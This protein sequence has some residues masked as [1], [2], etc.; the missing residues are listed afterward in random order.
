MASTA[1]NRLARETSP[2]LLQH[3][4]N[5]VDWYPWGPEA[6]ARA[7]AE[8]KPILLSIGYSACHWCHVMERESFEDPATAALMNRD[9]V[10][11][12]VDREERPDLD[13]LYQLSIQ[14]LGRQGGWPLTVF[15]SPDL[16]PF[17]GGT[18]FPPAPRYGLPSFQQVLQGLADA[19]RTRRADV[20]G[21]AAQ[22][23]DAVRQ[24]ERAECV[25]PRSALDRSGVGAAA[26]RLLSRFDN[27]NGGFGERPKFPNVFALELWQRHAVASGDADWGDRVRFT[28][29]RMVRGGIY[30]QLGGGFHRYSTDERWLVPHFEKMLYDN[31]LLLRLI[32]NDHRRAP[33]PALARVLRETG[34]WA[35]REMQLPDGGFASTQD[36]DSEGEEG[37]F[38]AWSP[39][40][41]V[42][43][44][45]PADAAFAARAL[46][47]EPAG[48]FEHGASV[49]HCPVT[50]VDAA[51]ALGLPTDDA[52]ERLDSVRRRLFAARERR[53]RPGRDDKV[54][55]GWNGLLIHGLALAG[56]VLDEPRFLVA[57]QRASRFVEAALDRDGRLLRTWR[58]GRAHIDAFAEDYGFLAEGELAL[59]EA[60]GEPRHFARA[61][62]LLRRALALFADPDAGGFFLTR[63][64]G[65]PLFER[66]RA[67]YDNAVPG[68][69]SSL[70]HALLRQH[71]LTGEPAFWGAAEAALGSLGA[72]MSRNPSGFS[73]LLAALDAAT[74]GV[75]TLVVT[76]RPADLARTALL[77]AA[78]AR[79]LPNLL[80][81]PVAPGTVLP[82]G[83]EA[84]LEGKDRAQSAA[85]LCRAGACSLPVADPAALDRLL[86]SGR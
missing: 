22:L 59:F 76:G 77:A 5:P 82:A 44:I 34:D 86:A 10:S 47:V 57:A 25:G 72:A 31:A 37:R 38:F 20:I 24:V 14:V 28:L 63:A 40:Q 9:Y 50:A 60:T 42:D 36:A 16:R 35:L 7:V 11:I 62:S 78:R 66:P 21:N 12:K 64:D 48:N 83:L 3:A 80:V 1:R 54:L 4:G 39:A 67:A 71:A 61:D 56:T 74:A 65:E 17:F 52:D 33:S 32:A 6:L 58:A 51:R 13:H 15:L 2:Y 81:V 8:D 45:G 79:L 29:E 41:L 84:L 73:Y 18:Y 53:A 43:A 49:L 23:S 19:W 27:E 75:G 55:A 30:D 46:G 85:F 69:T 68:A 70:C 26:A